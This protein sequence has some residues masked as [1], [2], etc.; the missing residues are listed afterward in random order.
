MQ[1][2]MIQHFIMIQISHSWGSHGTVA[3]GVCMPVRRV[4]VELNQ[5]VFDLESDAVLCP[6]CSLYCKT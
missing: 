5:E 2:Y 4:S 6:K 3:W 1:S